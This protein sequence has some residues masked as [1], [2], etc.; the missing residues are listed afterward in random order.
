M[1]AFL[2]AVLSCLVPLTACGDETDPLAPTDPPTDAPT[3]VPTATP[4]NSLPGA[5]EGSYE[6]PGTGVGGDFCVVLAVDPAEAIAGEVRFGAEE[7][8]PIAG[9][10]AGES[11]GFEWGLAIGGRT[12]AAPEAPEFWEGGRVEGALSAP[13]VLEGTWLSTTGE[14]GDWTAEPTAVESCD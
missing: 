9:G 1:K 6:E 10:A 2:L 8:L 12:P 13:G 5:W 3:A 14:T 7:V 4:R 11:F